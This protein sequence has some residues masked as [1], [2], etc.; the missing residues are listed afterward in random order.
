MIVL[1]LE[2]RMLN[3]QGICTWAAG[4]YGRCEACAWC[5]KSGGLRAVLKLQGRRSEPADCQ[6]MLTVLEEH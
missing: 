6:L 1:L 4:R 5:V 3:L 2:I